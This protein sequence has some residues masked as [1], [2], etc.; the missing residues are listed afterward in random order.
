VLINRSMWRQTESWG[1][2]GAR[3]EGHAGA[4]AGE[5]EDEGGDELSERRLEGARVVHLLGVADGDV[6]DR[7]LSSELSLSLALINHRRGEE[8]ET[9]AIAQRWCGRR[10]ATGP[11]YI[12][13]ARACRTPPA[14]GRVGEGRGPP[15][16]VCLRT[17]LCNARAGA[18]FFS[19]EMSCVERD[20][21]IR[22]CHIRAS[23][24]SLFR[25]KLLEPIREL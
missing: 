8:E 11:V 21:P 5:D 13:G 6:A 7:H 22:A 20:T 16:R 12:H 14:P 15:G 3:T 1:S 18:Y 9:A 25:V 23:V 24:A 4:L 19:G 10:D 2:E 17:L